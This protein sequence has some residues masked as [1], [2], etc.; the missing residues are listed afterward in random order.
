VVDCSPGHR[1]AVVELVIGAVLAGALGV[2][3]LRLRRGRADVMDYHD[4]ETPRLDEANRRSPGDGG[5]GE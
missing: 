5:A 4:I 3:L 1:E 2:A